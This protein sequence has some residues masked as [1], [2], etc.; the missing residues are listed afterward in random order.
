VTAGEVPDNARIIAEQA[1]RIAQIIRQLLDFARKRAPARI[2]TD[3]R[4][5]AEHV[6][7]LLGQIADARGVKLALHPGPGPCVALADDGQI[8]Q[9]LMNVIGNGIQA[10]E[11]GGC[12]TIS[13]SARHATPPPDQGGP[14]RPYCCLSV[15]DD[16][17]GMDA[18]TADRIFEPFFTTKDVGAGTGLGLSVAYG[19]IREHDGFIAVETQVGKGSTFTIHLPQAPSEKNV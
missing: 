13:L 16:G 14:A 12:V 2:R 6:L 4:V 3:L 10:T 11:R 5:T 17:C 18:T 1:K 7:T 8:Q 19:I 9:V 15:K